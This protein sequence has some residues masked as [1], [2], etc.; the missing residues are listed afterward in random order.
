MLE[1]RDLSRER[2]GGRC[3]GSI[4]DVAPGC[5]V[6]GQ[7]VACSWQGEALGYGRL[8]HLKRSL[9]EHLYFS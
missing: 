9:E 2:T 5:T 7:T 1:L 4:G 3:R 6:S 8:G